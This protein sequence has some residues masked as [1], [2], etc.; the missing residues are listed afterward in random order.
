MNLAPV[1]AFATAQLLEEIS[2]A[3][4]TTQ[5]AADC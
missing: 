2:F 5:T 4:R 3:Q 1:R